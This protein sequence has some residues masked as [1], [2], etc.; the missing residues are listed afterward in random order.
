MRPETNESVLKPGI[1]TA[2][3]DDT[4]VERNAT[5]HEQPA[6]RLLADDETSTV[7]ILLLGMNH[8]TAP[9]ELRERFAASDPA[10]ALQ[11]LAE[12]DEI[13]EAML[14]STCNR[15]E[16][17][18]T[19]HRPAAARHRL[20]HFMKH[21][22][23]SGA[24]PPSV[25]LEDFTYG[26]ED[27]E[28]VAHVFRVASSIDSMVVGEPQILGQVKDAYRAASEMG[29]CGPL[30]SR[31]FQRAFATAKRVK[32]ETRIGERPVSVPRVAVRLAGKIFEE[33]SDKTALLIGAGEMIE[34]ALESLQREGLTAVR[35]ANR[36]RKNAAALARRFDASAH[37][38][39]ELD[40]LLVEADVV[41]SCIGG[42]GP[43]LDRD[44]VARAL[45]ARDARPV[46]FI[47][48]GVPRNVDP[49]VN[50]LDNA[51]LYDLD[52]LQD[53]ADSNA[54]ER[55]REGQKAEEIIMEEQRGFD[56][57]LIAQQAVP[58]IRDLRSRAEEIRIGAIDRAA[59]RLGLDDMQEEQREALD[60][61]TRSIV[62]KLLHNP[63]SRLRAESG[64]E[65]GPVMFEAA[66]ELFGLDEREASPDESTTARDQPRRTSRRTAVRS[67]SP[68]RPRPQGV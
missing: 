59:H 34:L 14:L 18:V 28:A 15:V 52:D 44:R 58:T 43:L 37:E 65:E 51:Y 30:L 67:T 31:L 35:I 3:D 33:L 49:D 57:W 8:R 21:D 23:G 29:A 63:L 10:A 17:V 36:T 56:G 32:N 45:R 11:K 62:N 50:S 7:K 22:L 1:V 66:R 68:L 16:L 9:I 27:D 13:K 41:L 54:K 40:D 6:L 61:L 26:Y 64:R 2:L 20:L 4:L 47:D 42:D 48:I 46:F 53:I 38:F 55:R 39:E 12:S 5:D 60:M 24:L 25:S 19:T